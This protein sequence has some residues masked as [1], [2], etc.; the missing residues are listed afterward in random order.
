MAGRTLS[1]LE[2]HFIPYRAAEQ[3]PTGPVLIL[4]PHPDDEV[5]GCAGAIVH[6]RSRAELLTVCILTDGA[7][8]EQHAC[9]EDR[10]AY[11]RLRESESRAAA[12]VLGY[13]NPVFWRLQDRSLDRDQGLIERLTRCISDGG[14]RTVFAPSPNE[15]HPDHYATARAAIEA[16]K[17]AASATHLIFYEIGVP[18][19][20]NLL[21]DISKSLTLKMSAMDCF[22]SQLTL[23]PYDRHIRG[24]NEY[25][26]YT[27]PRSVTAAEAYRTV[28]REDLDDWFAIFGRSRCSELVREGVIR[29]E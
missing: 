15:I 19:C 14:F 12:G 24:L 29:P 25:R 9:T 8:A 20:P 21:L 22:R 18:Q 23:Q 16:V 4:A 7:S 26:S 3:L 17:G 28:A 1:E 27:L 6:Y 13:T 11:A 10:E 2:H 5:L